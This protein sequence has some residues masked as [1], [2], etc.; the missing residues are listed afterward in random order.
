VNAIL[1]RRLPPGILTAPHDIAE[2]RIWLK[3]LMRAGLNIRT[4]NI[5]LT[6]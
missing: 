6:P 3:D 2:V 4:K 5:D 1:A